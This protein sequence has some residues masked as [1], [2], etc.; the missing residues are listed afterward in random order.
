MT[1]EVNP[2]VLGN[3][4]KDGNPLSGTFINIYHQAEDQW[5]N[6]VADQNGNFAFTVPDGE[7]QLQGIWVRFRIQVVSIRSIF[8]SARWCGRPA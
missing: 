6:A 2:N 1:T 4:I 5:Y 7:Y 3:L 8:Y